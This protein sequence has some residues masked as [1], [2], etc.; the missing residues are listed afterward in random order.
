MLYGRTWDHKLQFL[1]NPYSTKP[2]SIEQ[3]LKG[4]IATDPTL[5]KNS[6]RM[7]TRDMVVI[8][9]VGCFDRVLI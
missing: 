3:D 5:L 2:E 9:Y 7:T 6:A 1:S 4:L 8:R